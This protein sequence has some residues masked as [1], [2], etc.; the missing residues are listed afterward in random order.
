[1]D[2]SLH[3]QSGVVSCCLLILWFNHGEVE[4]IS[5]YS[6]H[7]Q[8]K[9]LPFRVLKQKMLPYMNQDISRQPFESPEVSITP[10]HD[11]DY[12]LVQKFLNQVRIYRDGLTPRILEDPTFRKILRL[13][14]LK[15]QSKRKAAIAP[16]PK[17]KPIK[18]S[19]TQT[20]R[21]LSMLY[22]YNRIFHKLF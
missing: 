10:I 21:P 22:P 13:S 17:P 11:P 6:F 12:W 20:K 15:G 8:V 5:Q 2:L 18:T 3:F 19:P 7:R 4:A 1:M 9:Q 14:Y 16:K